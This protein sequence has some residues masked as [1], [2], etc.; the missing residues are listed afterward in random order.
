[1][2]KAIVAIGGGAIKPGG[3][4]AI[5]REVIRLSHKKHPR[6]LFIPTASSD[7]G[8]F[9]R[10]FRDY[11]G[12]F[13]GC[14]TD[15]LLLVNE[16][17]PARQMERQILAADIVYVGG[18]NTLFM[19]RLWRRL[20]VDRILKRAYERGIILSGISAGAIC[21]F[22]SGHSDSMSFYQPQDW[23]Y[24]NVRGLGLIPGVHCP[25]YN[26]R[27]RGVPRRK[28][29]Q[30]MIGTIGGV[31]IAIENHCAIEFID[32]QAYR[33]IT[34][35]PRARAYRVYKSGGL[36]VSEQ[37]PKQ[38]QLAPVGRLAEGGGDSAGRTG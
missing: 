8:P 19:M 28:N 16:R 23:K 34:A 33:V 10:R 6:V 2:A 29:F 7:D 4:E 38:E 25:H 26:G 36:V 5:D 32:G 18:G 11:F 27:T 35:K 14:L 12:G 24:I 37:I 9:C 31:G 15:T 21:W 13:L 22:E 1:M 30:E 17:P 20:G 3:T